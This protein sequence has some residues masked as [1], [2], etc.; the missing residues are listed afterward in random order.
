MFIIINLWFSNLCW[1]NN[2]SYDWLQGHNIVL[3]SN[4]QTE[5]DPAVI[6]LLLESTNP[7]I[8]ESL[9]NLFSS[10]QTQPTIVTDVTL[11]IG[12]CWH[13]KN[14]LDVLQTYIA[15]DRVLTDP[16]CKPFSKGRWFWSFQMT[17]YCEY[18]P[19][20]CL[21]FNEFDVIVLFAFFARNLLCVYSKKHMYDVPELVEIKK[22][23][24]TRSLKEMALLLRYLCLSLWVWLKS[25]IYD[26]SGHEE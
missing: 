14:I 5:A 11:C 2:F 22:K 15:G 3:M 19:Y 1:C 16:L 13:N 4:H 21:N 26:V 25:W 6:A 17:S 10:L 7:R 24:N 20:A 18:A 8:A 12:K 9:V 23:A